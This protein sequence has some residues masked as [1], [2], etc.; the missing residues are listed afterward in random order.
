[1]SRKHKKRKSQPRRP[2]QSP[3]TPGQGRAVLEEMAA[4]VQRQGMWPDAEVRINA[5]GLDKMSEILGEFIAPFADAAKNLEQYEKLVAL[6][7]VAWDA[8]LLDED[9]RKDFL[10]DIASTFP[11]GDRRFALSFINTL[12][13]R[14]LKHFP[15]V[16]SY[17]V[18]A[19]V[20]DLGDHYHLAVLSHQVG[21]Q[22]QAD[23]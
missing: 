17:I 5:P 6:A 10:A 18:Q 21:Q 7:A 1:M 9:K 14:K 19:R 13:R 20:A 3:M 22:G 23:S 2:A 15:H 11:A 4:E 12:I 16:K 8:A